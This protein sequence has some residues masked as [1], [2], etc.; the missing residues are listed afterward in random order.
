V[1]EVV[2]DFAQYRDIQVETEC[3][4]RQSSAQM[5]A[6][7]KV[8]WDV[9]EIPYLLRSS[10][11]AATGGIHSQRSAYECALEP[12]NDVLVPIIPQRFPDLVDL[13]G[14]VLECSLHV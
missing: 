12:I 9:P 1:P 7:R 5:A 13:I 3:E 8:L 6:V 11:H 2:S 10:V 4:L 14:S